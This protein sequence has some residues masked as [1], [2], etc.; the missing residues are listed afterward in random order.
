MSIGVV[1]ITRN[2]KQRLLETLSQLRRLPGHPPVVLVDNGSSDGTCRAVYEQHPWVRVL[3]LGTNQGGA[4]R[5]RGVR[6]LDTDLVAFCDDDSW[7]EPAALPI[8]ERLL[9]AHPRLGLIA[10]RVLV[11]PEGR[12][13]PLCDEMAISALPPLAGLPG[14]RVLGFLACAAVVRRQAFLEAGGFHPQLGVGGEEELLAFD[15]RARGWELVYA[16]R[17]VA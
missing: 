6:Y 4:A 14:P 12:L 5:N 13:D 10:G 7:W 3:A 17:V 15:L 16:D 8:A 1:V 2:R 11:E 9:E